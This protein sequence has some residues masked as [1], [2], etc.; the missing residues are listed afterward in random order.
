[1]ALM[2]AMQND[3]QWSDITYS[4]MLNAI[5]TLFGKNGRDAGAQTDIVD[6]IGK[7]IKPTYTYGSNGSYNTYFETNGISSFFDSTREARQTARAMRLKQLAGSIITDESGKK[8]I[9]EGVY[10]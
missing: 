3:P 6:Q 1:M 5:S 4:D 2:R 8:T 7:Y 10:L 9:A